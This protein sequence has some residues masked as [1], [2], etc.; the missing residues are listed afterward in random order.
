LAAPTSVAAK[1]YAQYS[2]KFV[3]ILKKYKNYMDKIIKKQ[4]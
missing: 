3:E 4:Y 2:L 1:R